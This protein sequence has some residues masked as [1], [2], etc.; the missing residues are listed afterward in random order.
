MAETV[1][2]LIIA[3]KLLLKERKLEEALIKFEEAVKLN[4]NSVE[5]HESAAAAHFIGSDYEAAANHYIEITGLKP[6]E[7]KAYFNL[8]AIYNKLGDHNRSI[9]WIRKGIQRDKRCAEGYYN[10]GIAHRK[11]GQQN[12]AITAY[13][14]AIRLN[15]QFAEA[16][17]NLANLYADMNNL[18]MAVTNFK[19]AL[20][21]RPDFSRAKVGL[22]RVEGI[23]AAKRD[24]ND[25]LKRIAEASRASGV[26]Q[27]PRI[28]RVLSE[29]ERIDDRNAIREIAS[30][31]Q[32]LS[33]E[34]LDFLANK[35]NPA[36]L[37]LNRSFSDGAMATVPLGKASR[38]FRLCVERWTEL[39][40][41][42]KRKLLELRAHEELVNAPSVDI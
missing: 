10:L 28:E 26:M 42:M 38:D 2:D 33:K 16:Y 19:K 4:P 15:G 31:I 40:R 18:Q 5:A 35:V 37:T 32:H 36:L 13:R 27:A 29:R 1:E 34:C 7:A 25:P 8:G 30:Q 22:E 20:E 14:E 6:M 41:Q 24:A 12:M 21:V 3:G 17:Q 9:E 39:R 23:L 11:L